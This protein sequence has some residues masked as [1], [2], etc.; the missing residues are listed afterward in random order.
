M[1]IIRNLKMSSNFNKNIKILKMEYNKLAKEIHQYQKA[2]GWYDELRSDNTLI[3][4]IK[5]ELFEAFE[6]YRKKPK[7]EPLGPK[8]LDLLLHASQNHTDKFISVFKDEVKDSFADELADT[9]IRLLDFAG[10]KKIHIGIQF[11]TQ[12]THKNILE[13]L[14]RLDAFLTKLYNQE[15]ISGESIFYIISIIN[16]IAHWCK[17]DLEIHMKLKLAYNKTRGKRHGNKAV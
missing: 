2:A 12:R 17:I 13:S 1:G 3:L 16:C 6:A 10:Y 4:L 5:S 8:I 15:E 14:V 11:G 9:V 7:I